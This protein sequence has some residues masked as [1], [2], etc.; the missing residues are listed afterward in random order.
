MREGFIEGD[1]LLA[2]GAGDDLVGHGGG[3]VANVPLVNKWYYRNMAGKNSYKELRRSKTKKIVFG[4]CGG[5]GE[6][7]AVDPTIVR[8]LLVVLTVFTGFF[9]GLIFYLLAAA[10]MPER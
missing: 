3:R 8:L 7:F 2:V 9:P 5:V 6:Y 10:I 1:L 4:I